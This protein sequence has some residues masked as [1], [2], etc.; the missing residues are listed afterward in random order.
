MGFTYAISMTRPHEALGLRQPMGRRL[1]QGLQAWNIAL[2]IVAIVLTGMYVV[3]VSGAAAKSYRLRDVERRVETLKTEATIL[4][5]EYI[6]Q[7]SLKTLSGKATELGF[8]PVD[9]IQYV[10]SNPSGYALA[11]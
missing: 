6:G 2:S 4:Q 7:T 1:P 9:A 5:N 8:V 11:R 3:E 10:Q